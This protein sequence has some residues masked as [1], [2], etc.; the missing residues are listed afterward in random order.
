[1]NRLAT[2]AIACT[3]IAAGMTEVPF[4]A[5]AAVHVKSAPALAKHAA[6]DIDGD[7]KSDLVVGSQNNLQ[8]TYT[9]AS[10]GGSH[11]QTITLP[12]GEWPLSIVVG[13]FNG[14][15]FADVAVGSP[16]SRPVKGEDD[17]ED[18]EVF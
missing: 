18:G 2:A 6:G 4:A 1:M 17:A 7:G 5:A 12:D 3:L 8:I 16:F 14:D 10:P 9:S 15:G 11:V 13:D